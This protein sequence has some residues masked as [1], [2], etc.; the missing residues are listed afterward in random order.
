MWLQSLRKALA[1]ESA[2]ISHALVTHWHPD[3]VGGIGD[4]R[5]LCPDAQ[6][7][8]YNLA[9]KVIPGIEKPIEHGQIFKTDGATL[10]AFHCPGHTK[11]HMSFILSEE[12]AMFTGDNVLGH[13]TAVFE[14]LNVYLQSLH[15]MRKQF[16]GRAYP[17]HGALIEDGPRKI[18]EYI[19]HRQQR[20][21]EVLRALKDF[22]DD[23]TPM[24]IVKIVYQDVPKNLHEPAAGGVRQ[25]LEKLKVDGKVTK[26]GGERWQIVAGQ[27]SL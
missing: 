2:T 6:V 22:D 18:S 27:S 15:H 16:S 25:V 21:E 23:A 13:G 26:S 8:K 3:H 14:D 5:S 24:E 9:G 1:S 10:R 19:A 17:G 4:L 20:E 11:D 12:Q 7:Y